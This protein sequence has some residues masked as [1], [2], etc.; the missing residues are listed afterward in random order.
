M[1]YEGRSVQQSKPCLLGRQAVL[2]AEGRQLGAQLPPA[3]QVLEVRPGGGPLQHLADLP[4]TAIQQPD[5]P[6]AGTCCTATTAVFDI[7]PTH[8]TDCCA[9]TAVTVTQSPPGRAHG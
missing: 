1:T 2:P 5:R 8:P 7:R 9:L 3:A 4:C 6:A